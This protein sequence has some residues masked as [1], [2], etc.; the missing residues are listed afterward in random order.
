MIFKEFLTSSLGKKYVM[1][2][3]G[4]FLILFLIVHATIN[5]TIFL[6]D[7]GQT[8]ETFAH[9]MSRNYIMRFLE[10]GLF[11]GIILHIIQGLMLTAQNNKA[12]PVKYAMNKAEKNSKWYSRSMGLLGTLILLFLIM[13]LAHFWAPTKG[14]LYFGATHERTMYQ[15]MVEVFSNPL[16][17]ALYMVGLVA[18]FFHLKHGFSSAFQSLG[19][20]S[21]KY[22]PFLI[23]L[24][25]VY[26]ILIILAF[27]LM[28]LSIFFGWLS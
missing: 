18:L 23:G 22:T 15:E 27:A 16:W 28:P 5:G 2:I 24:G 14:E 1:A 19:L 20:N 10:I 8:F 12:R 11:A 13:H 3:T 6:N 4:I 7:G 26:T 25:N 17:V 9:F 21:K